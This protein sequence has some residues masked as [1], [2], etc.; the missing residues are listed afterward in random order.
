MTCMGPI[1]VARIAERMRARPGESYPLE[2][3][4][5][6]AGLSRYQFIRAFRDAAGE[7]PHA[8]LLRARV[9]RAKALLAAG[10]T[11]AAVAH[12]CGFSDQSHL[13]SAF[14]RLVGSTPA[15]FAR[16]AASEAPDAAPSHNERNVP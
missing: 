12:D 10:C 2:R 3:L 6:E 5:R 7:T 13:T 15:Q 11:P 4:A 14:R 1:P 16:A 9:E 8:Y